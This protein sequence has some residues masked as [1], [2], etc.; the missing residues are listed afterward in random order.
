L[1]LVFKWFYVVLSRLEFAWTLQKHKFARSLWR[2][3]RYE[4]WFVDCTAPCFFLL[5]YFL[6]IVCQ[7]IICRSADPAGAK[8]FGTYT[9]YMYLPILDLQCNAV[10]GWDIMFQT[11]SSQPYS[12]HHCASFFW[13]AQMV[14]WKSDINPEK[15]CRTDFFVWSHSVSR[16]Y[17]SRF[18]RFA[19]ELTAEWHW[20]VML[21]W[22][23]CMPMYAARVNML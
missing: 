20:H 15:N 14:A 21:L 13:L 16:M 1:D 17:T 11:T 3:C 19:P 2:V 10:Y 18:V 8:H 22:N 12:K 6:P 9:R 23:T 7:A 5:K 4:A